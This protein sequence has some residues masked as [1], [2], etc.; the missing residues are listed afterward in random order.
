MIRE[1]Y[2]DRT[3]LLT[4][5]T[6]FLGKGIVAKMLRDLSQVR[7]IYTLVRPGKKSDDNP[8]SA[9]QR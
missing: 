9:A 5:A 4:G 6:G 8:V 3:I 7:R 1:F 2:Q